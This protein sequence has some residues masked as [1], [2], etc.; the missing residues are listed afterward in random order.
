MGTSMGHSM[1]L[2]GPHSGCMIGPQWTHRA[3][4]SNFIKRKKQKIPL[5]EHMIRHYCSK[6]NN[7]LS[8]SSDKEG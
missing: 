1:E 7:Y 2:P 3:F 4:G 6:F 5:L 8:S